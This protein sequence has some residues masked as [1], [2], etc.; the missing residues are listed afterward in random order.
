VAALRIF[1]PDKKNWVDVID[2]GEIAMGASKLEFITS[3]HIEGVNSFI[4]TQG[5]CFFKDNE[6]VI[7][8]NSSKILIYFIAEKEA[9]HL[10]CEDIEPEAV[11]FKFL[12]TETQNPKLKIYFKNDTTETKDLTSSLQRFQKGRGFV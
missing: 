2:H 11:A 12:E 9:L 5:H 7:L 8:W 6:T 1:S 4:F 3:F 10:T